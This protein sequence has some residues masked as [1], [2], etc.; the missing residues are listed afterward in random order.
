MHIKYS[1]SAD[2]EVETKLAAA[3]DATSASR[4][5]KKQVEELIEGID[6]MFRDGDVDKA[7][8]NL[9]DYVLAADELD[10]DWH[11]GKIFKLLASN[12]AVRS[13]LPYCT[14]VIQRIVKRGEES[15]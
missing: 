11:K 6:E 7:V 15:A 5:I 4:R 10:N 2:W 14:D 13:V 9:S 3:V 12:R 8:N 1:M